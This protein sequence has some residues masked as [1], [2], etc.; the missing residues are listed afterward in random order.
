MI[1]RHITVKNQLS[2]FIHCYPTAPDIVSHLRN[3][4]RHLLFVES[5][6]EVFHNDRELEFFLV[7]DFIEYLLG[8]M[9]VEANRSCEQVAEYILQM[10]QHRY[11]KIRKITVKVF[12]D[13]INGAIVEYLPD[14]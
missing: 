2:G 12:E 14:K 6:I 11:G 4:H 10:L 13:N 5:T 7:Q 3:A 9:P 8:E 1:T